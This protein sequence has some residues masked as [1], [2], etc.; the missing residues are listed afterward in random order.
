MESVVVKMDEKSVENKMDEVCSS[1]DGEDVD[2]EKNEK[3]RRRR[4][5]YRETTH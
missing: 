2:D 3:T 1:E 5:L 4:G